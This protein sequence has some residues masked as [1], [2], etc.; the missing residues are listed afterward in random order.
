[1]KNLKVLGLVFFIAIVFAGMQIFKNISTEVNLNPK[2]KLMAEFSSGRSRAGLIDR[3]IELGASNL[4]LMGEGQEPELKPPPPPPLKNEKTVTTKP[5][6]KRQSRFRK[7]L[8]FAFIASGNDVD[9]KS[10]PELTTLKQSFEKLDQ[11]ALRV[12]FLSYEGEIL[13]F[14]F[15]GAAINDVY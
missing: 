11:G 9:K 5:Q 3:A 2:Q 4:E 7:H 1:M 15:S 8:L 14:E 12:T 13:T 10:S 6:D